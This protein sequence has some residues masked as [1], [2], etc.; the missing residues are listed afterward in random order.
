MT[1]KGNF[2]V[3][4][5]ENQVSLLDITDLEGDPLNIYKNVEQPH[6]VVSNA[7][8]KEGQRGVEEDRKK[9]KNSPRKICGLNWNKD[10]GSVEE[11]DA[12][13]RAKAIARKGRLEKIIMNEDDAEV[14]PWYW[15][16]FG[17]GGTLLGMV[18]VALA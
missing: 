14:I 3:S 12:Q 1:G 17:F 6:F 2:T 16:F 8:K 7:G 5:P 10:F 18:A 15:A 9:T 13:Q 4:L 11:V